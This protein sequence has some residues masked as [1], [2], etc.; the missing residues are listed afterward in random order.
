MASNET[1]RQVERDR[2]VAEYWEGVRAFGRWRFIWMRGALGWGAPWG[3]G[4][5]AWRWWDTGVSPTLSGV[6][7]MAVL[8][9][10]GGL[11][12]GAFLWWQSER[13]YQRW[14]LSHAASVPRIFE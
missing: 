7:F 6:L 11:A 3:I 9:T 12:F 2:R 1:T 8:A 13:R 5:L 14:L 10:T 4:M